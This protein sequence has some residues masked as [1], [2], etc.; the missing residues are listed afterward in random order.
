VFR[1]FRHPILF[2]REQAYAGKYVIQT[3]E[4][5]LSEVDAVRL[6]KE[7]SEVERSFANLK[8][9]IS[10]S[11]AKPLSARTRMR[12]CGRRRRI[13]TGIALASARQIGPTDPCRAAKRPLGSITKSAGTWT[14][15]RRGP[16]PCI[17]GRDRLPMKRQE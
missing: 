13:S 9:A 2:A 15:P 16:F 6:Y 4:P 17:L 3:E 14:R 11:R 8:D 10:S 7:L 5:N 1:F 12:T